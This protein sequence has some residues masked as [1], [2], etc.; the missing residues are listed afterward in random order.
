MLINVF[1]RWINPNQITRL[2]YEYRNITRVCFSDECFLD[3]RD[4]TLEEIANEINRLVK[5]QNASKAERFISH[6]IP[7]Y[8]CK[9]TGQK[10]DPIDLNACIQSS[11][12]MSGESVVAYIDRTYPPE[13]QCVEI[14]SR[15]DFFNR[16]KIGE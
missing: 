12:I 4:K 5:E 11:N 2:T 10:V 15:P 6:P 14:L 8:V 3:F 16:F 1:G 13:T 9:K 7:Q